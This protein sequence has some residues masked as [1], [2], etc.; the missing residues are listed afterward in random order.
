M[1][2]ASLPDAV[3]TLALSFLASKDLASAL[4]TLEGVDASVGQT[5]A[6]LALQHWVSVEDLGL[7]QGDETWMSVWGLVDGSPAKDKVAWLL[8]GGPQGPSKGAFDWAWLDSKCMR[9]LKAEAC[10]KRLVAAAVRLGDAGRWEAGTELIR[11][12]LGDGEQPGD[13]IAKWLLAKLLP[14]RLQAL[15]NDSRPDATGATPADAAR[16]RAHLL[17]LASTFL[18]DRLYA[19]TYVTD[20]SQDASDLR[21]ASVYAQDAVGLCRAAAAAP[22]ADPATEAPV[23]DGAAP[24]SRAPRHESLP[25]LEGQLVDAL[26]ACG[27]G[28]AL[29]AQHAALGAMRA[30][31][32]Y[33]DD[34]FD[35]GLEAFAEA[36]SL[37]QRRI[38][39]ADCGDFFELGLLRV[40]AAKAELQY[41]RAS[42]LTRTARTPAAQSR[43]VELTRSSIEG[44][45]GALRGLDALGC[46]E[47]AAAVPMLKDLGKVYGFLSHFSGLR[48]DV[49]EAEKYLRRA[50]ALQQRLGGADHRNTK[51]VRRLLRLEDDDADD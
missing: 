11:H 2:L 35:A 43:V 41:C 12:A 15:R 51:N 8:F 37:C 49:S 46:A 19:N 13:T 34:V 28:G 50:L 30:A 45:L 24:A 39:G 17:T 29:L 44:T 31:A 1:A 22:A 33:A 6:W 26:L 10:V 40:S 42:G 5:S 9:R 47:T 21:R 27:R 7:F 20:S 25:P 4:A 16:W 14:N 3:V 32:G 38:D 23:L 18:I 48:S 36:A